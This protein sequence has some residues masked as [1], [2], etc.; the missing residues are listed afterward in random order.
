MEGWRQSNA[1]TVSVCLSASISPELHVLAYLHEI[2]THVTW[3]SGSV[4]LWRR[5]DGLCTSG[6]TDDDVVF[7]HNGQGCRCMTGTASQPDGA[8]RRLGRGPWRKQQ[9]VSPQPYNVDYCKPGAK[10]A[11]CERLVYKAWRLWQPAPAPAG[12]GTG[13]P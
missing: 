8:A 6:F 7:A 4:F 11:V 1:M 3:T 5:C 13:A 10:S 2:F 12:G 9:A